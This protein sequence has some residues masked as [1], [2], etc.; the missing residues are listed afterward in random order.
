MAEALAGPAPGRRRLTAGLVVL[1]WVAAVAVAAT[2]AWVVVDRAGISLLGGRGPGLSG[3]VPG[4]TSTASSTASATAGHT[5]SLSSA[6]NRVTATC[7][8]AGVISLGGAIPASKWAVEVKDLSPRLKV[9]F[10]RSGQPTVEIEGVCQSGVPVLTLGHGAANPTGST[11]STTDDHG[12][13]RPG[14]GGSSSSSGGDDGGGS[15]GGGGSGGGSGSGG[16][17]S[18]GSGKSGSGSDG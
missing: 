7:T 1:A 14:S 2:V 6:G 13:N 12:G 3:G 11:P 9:E 18:G 16:S 5:A 4:A 17:G 10:H 15:H 8:P